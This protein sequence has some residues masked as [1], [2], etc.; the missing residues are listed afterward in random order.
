[1]ADQRSSLLLFVNPILGEWAHKTKSLPHFNPYFAIKLS[2]VRSNTTQIE[3]FF[4]SFDYT[5]G[6]AL[7]T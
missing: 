7:E 6:Y 3:G 4:P 5:F 1:M 2:I